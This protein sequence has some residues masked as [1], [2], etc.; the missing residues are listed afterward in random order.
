MKVDIETAIKMK[1][2]LYDRVVKEGSDYALRRKNAYSSI[3][4]KVALGKLSEEIR[5][6][7]ILGELNGAERILRAIVE[8]KDWD[9][10]AIEAELHFFIEDLSEI[11]STYLTGKKVLG[12]EDILEMYGYYEK[13][14][15]EPTCQ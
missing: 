6:A 15:K 2:A 14:K 12:L 5:I 11:G 4:K 9:R 13:K 8:N 10:E 1:S 7:R 3:T